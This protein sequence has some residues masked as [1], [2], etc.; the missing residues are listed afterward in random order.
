MTNATLTLT[1]TS[2]AKTA[3]EGTSGFAAAAADNTKSSSDDTIDVAAG[4]ISD[5]AGNKASTDAV[6]NAA[7]IA[8]P[9]QRRR[10]SQ[11][12]TRLLPMVPMVWA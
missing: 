1:L 8:F 11:N 12:L 4:F 5:I 7:A 3:L 6:A 9:T 10:Q 2:D